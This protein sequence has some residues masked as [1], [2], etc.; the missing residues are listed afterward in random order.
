MHERAHGC[1]HPLPHLLEPRLRRHR[2]CRGAERGGGGGGPG[3]RRLSGARAVRRPGPVLRPAP[4]VQFSRKV[5]EVED[6][7]LEGTSSFARST[8]TAAGRDASRGRRRGWP[9]EEGS[10]GARAPGHLGWA[11]GPAGENQ[12]PSYG[13]DSV[14]QSVL[15]IGLGSQGVAT[16]TP[17]RVLVRGPRRGHLKR[18]GQ[19]TPKAPCSWGSD[20]P[21]G[22]GSFSPHCS[23]DQRGLWAPPCATPSLGNSPI[24]QGRRA[25][26]GQGDPGS[27][28]LSV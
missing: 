16:G 4:P 19:A 17:G 10:W 23:P 9:P 25:G 21:P 12:G 24:G 1:S 3:R 7:M 8:V 13:R 14:P 28:S 5:G 26:L 11:P 22:S 20:L 6:G 27:L 18:R 15:Q 2:A